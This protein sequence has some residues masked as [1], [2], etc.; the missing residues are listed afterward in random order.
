VE[1]SAGRRWQ[2]SPVT[3]ESAKETVKTIAQGRPG[4]LGKPVVTMLVCY[5][6]FAR[7]AAGAASTRLSLRPLFFSE[8]KTIMYHS[9]VSRREDATACLN[10]SNVIACDKREAFAQGSACDEAIQTSLAAIGL[11]V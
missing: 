9:G 4:Y 7:E 6:H 5:I 8:A 11:A 2:K 3:G 10:C 1:C